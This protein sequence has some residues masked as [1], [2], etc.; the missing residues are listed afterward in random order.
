LAFCCGVFLY[1]VTALLTTYGLRCHTHMGGSR[2]WYALVRT[3]RTTD[4]KQ[5]GERDP[6][7]SS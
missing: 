5:H 4:N 7:F 3:P 2:D 1:R 6:G